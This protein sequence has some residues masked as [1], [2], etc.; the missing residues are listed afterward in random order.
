MGTPLSSTSHVTLVSCTDFWC[1]QKDRLLFYISST[2]TQLIFFVLLEFSITAFSHTPRAAFLTEQLL[3][4][5]EKDPKA[6]QTPQLAIQLEDTP[7]VVCLH[8][9]CASPAHTPIPHDHQFMM[10]L[11]NSSELRQL[12]QR[13]GLRAACSKSISFDCQQVPHCR[14]SVLPTRWILFLGALTYFGSTLSLNT[15]Q[16][17]PKIFSFKSVRPSVCAKELFHEICFIIKNELLLF[18]NRR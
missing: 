6:F 3:Q 4:V 12:S 13:C 8:G 14:L 16:A 7:V 10:F 2:V 1:R 11:L 5:K 18:P 17:F 9:Q 15:T